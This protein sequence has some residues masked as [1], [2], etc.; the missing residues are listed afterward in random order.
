MSHKNQKDYEE[1]CADPSCRDC[2]SALELCD[3]CEWPEDPRLW[4]CTSCVTSLAA[5]LLATL[6]EIATQK[7]SDEMIAESWNNPDW[8]SGWD[9]VIA[10]ARRATT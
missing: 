10:R 2:G 9:E 3:G 5:K 4:L 7:N 8:E 6:D 1:F